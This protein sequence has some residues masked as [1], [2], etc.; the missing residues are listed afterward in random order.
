MVE[1]FKEVEFLFI[2]FGIEG[3]LLL[4]EFWKIEKRLF[5]NDFG[6]LWEEVE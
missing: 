6:L 2:G 4:S 5:V 3:V 1:I